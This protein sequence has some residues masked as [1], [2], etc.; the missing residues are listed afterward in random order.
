MIETPFRDTAATLA[1]TKGYL[2]MQIGCDQ[3]R[4]HT[5]W[6]RLVEDGPWGGRA[7]YGRVT[8]PERDIIEPIAK[9]FGT[10]S[11]RVAEMIAA[12]WYGVNTQVGVS[13]RIRNLSHLLDA[14]NENDASLIEAIARRLAVD[15]GHAGHS[16]DLRREYSSQGDKE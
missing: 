13:N 14:L 7:G 12:D 5:W 2:R 9:L 4:S 10:T 11:E 6:K 8:P 16:S 1:R 3:V 15:H